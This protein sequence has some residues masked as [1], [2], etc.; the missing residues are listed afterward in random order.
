MNTSDPNDL[1]H[2][3]IEQ[4]LDATTKVQT[5]VS[6]FSMELNRR[7]AATAL[8]KSPRRFLAYCALMRLMKAH[9]HF[10]AAAS[11]VMVIRVPKD[12]S[13]DDFEYAAQIGVVVSRKGINPL[14]ILMHSSR[15]RRGRW[16]FSPSD[17]LAAQ[18]LIV[19]IHAGTEL[20]PELE[21]SADT[22]AAID[23]LCDHHLDSLA[24]QLNVGLLS[25]ADRSF[26][27]SQDPSFI[28]SVFRRGRPAHA[29]LTKLRDMSPVTTGGRP[30]VPLSHFG[31]AGVWAQQLSRDLQDWRSG[32]LSWAN[33]DKGVLLFGPPG[34]GKTSFAVSL[35]AECSARLVIASA[36][37]WQAHGHL[38]DLLKAMR[39]D[40][41]EARDH[42]PSILF[43]DE[44]DSFGD[45]RSLSGDNGQ[46]SVEVVNALLEAIDGAS[47]REGVIV[48][49]ATNMPEKLDPA[50]I[51]SGRLEKH[52][53]LLPP[54]LGERQR[55]LAYYLPELEGAPQLSWASKS[56]AGQT[57][58]DI[59]FIAR[60]ARRR[61]RQ[62]QRDL[63]IDDLVAQIPEQLLLTGEYLWRVC[64]HEAAHALVAAVLGVGKVISVEIYN[65]LPGGSD[66]GSAG[67]NVLVEYPNTPFR[68]ETH[69]RTEIVTAL[70]GMAAEQVIFGDR[71]TVSGGSRGSDIAEAT[72]LAH[73]MVTRFGLG[74]RLSVEVAD[75]SG[76]GSINALNEGP[77]RA[78][79]DAILGSEFARAKNIITARNTAL[80]A[81]AETLRDEKN[82]N[83]DRIVSL[84]KTSGEEVS[85]EYDLGFRVE[86][87]HSR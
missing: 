4:L 83:G 56:L 19:F 40:F 44:V 84:L 41:Q 63:I 21:I 43:L 6:G 24:R 67:G 23:V 29:A 9:N 53:Q 17:Y 69:Y 27:R 11:S 12:W 39:I 76:P 75:L 18:K 65:T 80:I 5:A 61:A 13:L 71:S 31:D 26:L 77:T 70:A 2:A 42:S 15:T 51:R 36:A 28:D 20:H 78:D 47:G 16:D 68:T 35:A 52:V 37:K 62:S 8:A 58:A 59:E 7:D 50:L 64:V 85:A 30:P 49:G 81:I 72:R 54:D 46:Y 57:G 22:T 34:V 3:A 74:K 60:Q 10:F 87:G 82:L 1:L 73:R 66:F 33:L 79:I 48:V 25:D 55:I 38:G 14:K 45:R 86:K 32:T